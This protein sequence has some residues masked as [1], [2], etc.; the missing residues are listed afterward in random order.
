MAK[1]QTITKNVSILFTCIGRRVSLL[2]SFRKAGKRLKISLSV[3]GTDNTELSPALQLC[4][5][6][7]LI[8]PITDPD[9]ISNL[10]AIVKA[11]RAKLLVPTIDTDLLILAQNKPK[12]AEAG[13]VMLVSEP[14][15]VEICQDKR[16][17][18]K[19]LVANGFDAPETISPQA[20]FPGLV[21]SNPGT[22][23]Q[24][25]T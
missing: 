1:L 3:S 11:N 22:A 4:D 6:K 21:Y 2:N 19:F 17:T 13:C 10:L 12:F 8:K 15:V 24:E 7:L 18:Y 16:K 14:D 5:K 20:A 25:R 23:L 9:Y